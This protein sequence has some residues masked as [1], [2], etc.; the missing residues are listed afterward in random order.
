MGWVYLAGVTGFSIWLLLQLVNIRLLFRRGS[1]SQLGR[2][3]IV[4]SPEDKP[5]FSFFHLIYI[6]RA[7]T[8]TLAEKEQIIS[9]ESEHARQ[10]H[11]LD[12]LL[13]TFLTTVFWFNPATRSYKKILIQLHEFEADARAV[14]NSD[15]NAYCRLLA[16]LALQGYFPIA[17]HFNESLTVKRI[18]MMRTVKKKITA[19]KAAALAASLILCFFVIACQDQVNEVAKSTITQTSDYPD[20]VR[21]DMKKF[22]DEHPQAKLTYLEGFPSDINQVLADESLKGR[23]VKV[24]DVDK[25]GT[26]Q[27]GVLMSDIVQHA[28]QL[29]TDN[30]IFM[31]VEK[32]PEFPGGFDGLKNFMEQNL[33]IPKGSAAKQGTVYVSMVIDEDG[34]V[35]E[36]KVMRGFD[37]LLDKIAL[38]AVTNLPRWTPGEQNGKKVKVRYVLPI[39]FG[40]GNAS[41]VSSIQPANNKMNVNS[42]VVKVGEGAFALKGRVT[43]ESGQ[44]LAGVNVHV[45]GT[46]RGTTTNADGEFQLES[47]ND[48]DQVAVLSFIGYNSERVAF[49]STSRGK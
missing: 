9:H 42:S 48:K 4:E 49:V 31:V 32:M 45:E 24:Y 18:E 30:N 40:N 21:L 5:T 25:N 19:W 44:P 17:S 36:A 29:R 33:I 47:E 13:L 37:T 22:A 2:F 34:T 11:S 27:K 23:I 15:V 6:G 38:N 14:E 28:G 20:Q 43:T 8:L 7:D 41:K 3:R 1:R 39:A 16:R 10:W 26:E 46:T 12:M 35:S